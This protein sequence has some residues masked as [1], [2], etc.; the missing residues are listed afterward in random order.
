RD[1]GKHFTVNQMVGKESVRA[2]LEGRDQGISYTEFSYMLLQ[3]Y[4][5][6][7]LYDAHG[8]RLQ[9][10][11]SDQWGN[12]T[13]GVELIRRRRGAQAFGLTSPLVLR[14]D[15]T[16]FGKTEA[17]TVWL[18][19]TRTSPYLFYQF[20]VVTDDAVVGAYLRYF[21]WLGRDEIA[22]LERATAD[23]PERREAQRA[24]AHEVTT[25]VHGEAEAERARRASEALFAGDLAALD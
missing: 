15:G 25:L 6:L 4:D 7:Q 5:F 9:L 18:D 24:L 21:T 20:L 17:G 22:S 16:K 10:G 1:I 2:R 3:A 11:G 13:L 23:H 12:I 14:A 8:C 19:P